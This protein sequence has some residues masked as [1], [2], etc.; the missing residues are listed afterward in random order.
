VP[1]HAT[2]E[3]DVRITSK[4]EAER[5]EAAMNALKPVNPDITLSLSGWDKRPP[6]EQT[7]AV[8]GLFER[9]KPIA[10][11]LGLNLSHGSTGG[12]SDAN[13]TAALGVPTLDGFGCP[14][15]GAH[16]HNEHILIDGL[17]ERS[18]L[19]AA[20]LLGL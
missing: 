1:A 2:A 8:M 3:I 18:A 5:V 14:G 16:A 20:V 11:T 6:M 19:M 12:A 13:F 17:L 15:A 7:P 10:A 4:A 9:V